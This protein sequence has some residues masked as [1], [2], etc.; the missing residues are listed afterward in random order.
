MKVLANQGQ[1]KGRA[2]ATLILSGG[3]LVE[4]KIDRVRFG[5]PFGGPFVKDYTKRLYKKSI[6]KVYTIYFYFSQRIG[7]EQPC[8]RCICDSRR[9]AGEGEIRKAI[10]AEKNQTSRY[11]NI[12]TTGKNQMRIVSS[13]SVTSIV[14]IANGQY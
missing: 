12:I 5:G 1:I 8:S 13:S 7:R 11:V 2:C 3:R 4:Y 10:G 9:T 6:R 14:Q